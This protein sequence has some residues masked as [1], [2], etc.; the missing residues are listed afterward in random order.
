MVRRKQAGLS[1]RQLAA[2]TG[3]SHHWFRRWEYDRCVPSQ[4]EWDAMGKLLELPKR[5]PPRW[6]N[7]WKGWASGRRNGSWASA[8]TPL[9][10]GCN[11]RGSARSRNRRPP[12]RWNGLRRMNYG[13][14]SPKKAASATSRLRTVPRA[15]VGPTDW[16]RKSARHGGQ[17]IDFRSPASAAM[18]PQII[19][20]QTLATATLV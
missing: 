9:P 13:L 3:F 17:C 8:T 12:K 2:K 16:A 1:H 15:G 18:S 20:S 14:I 7:I 6:R 4:A 10:T 5:R 11:R 19:R